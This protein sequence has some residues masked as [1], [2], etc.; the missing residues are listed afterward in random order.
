MTIRS[1]TLLVLL[2]LTRAAGA[3]QLWY[4]D[5][6]MGTGGGAPA[7]FVDKFR[8]PE[9]FRQASG[10]IN[11]YMLRANVLSKMD[12]AFFTQL[13]LPYVKGH[14]IKVAIDAG[15]ATWVMAPG[16]EKFMQADLDLYQRLKRLGLEVTYISLQ[17][18][19]SKPRRNEGKKTEFPLEQR[20]EGLVRYAKAARAIYPNVEIGIIDALA[21]HGEDYRGPYRQTRD[22]LA[23]AGVPLKY[24]HFDA[25]LQGVKTS[26]Y[27][28]SWQAMRELEAYV[29]N[30]LGLRF[31]VIMKSRKAGQ[32]SSKAFHESVMAMLDCYAGAG[33][34]PEDVIIASFFRYPDKTV[35][36]NATGDDYPA[37]RT[38]LEFGRRLHEI[39]RGGAGARVNE[40]QWRAMCGTGRAAAR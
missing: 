7:D 26:R 23:K 40:R 32:T 1:V 33:G 22:A 27:G 29:E 35:P 15:G 11:V 10:M 6:N 13:L 38:V 31:G 37:M 20:I 14:N 21:A 4:E 9:A 39:D 36:E 28:Q 18:V 12:D 17:S 16:R 3:T 25:N 19:L 8:H 30:D 34:T 2:A 5:N 24:V